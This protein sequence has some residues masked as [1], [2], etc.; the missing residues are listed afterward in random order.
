MPDSSEQKT[1][2]LDDVEVVFTGRTAKRK[3]KNDRI[4]ERFEVKP[5]DKELGSW[6]K[7]VRIT[8]LYEIE[9]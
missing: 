3:L 9:E 2:L 1:Y 7:W 8:D 4:D 5:A 6:T